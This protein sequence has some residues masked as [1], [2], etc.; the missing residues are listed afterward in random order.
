MLYRVIWTILRILFI[1]LGLKSEGLEN[2][3][4][5]GSFIIASNHVS[6]WDP[7]A[8]AVSIKRQISFIAKAEL[9]TNA[10]LGNLL[11]RVN[12]FPVK[13]GTADRKAIKQALEVLEQGKILG[14][15][16]EGQRKIGR[17]E[18]KAHAGIAM[19][20]LKSHVPVIPVACIGT[21]HKIPWGWTRPLIVKV[22][23]PI[24]LE[25]YREQKIN[26][27]IMEEVSVKIMQ[28]INTLLLK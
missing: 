2:I 15:F 10:L 18:T 17:M 6:N 19:L 20:A 12:A 1:L 13:R 25:E 11:T 21:N 14:I 3:P 5:Q 27:S 23:K 16:P 24:C 8:V 22:G 7:I 28:E 26:S 9:F 4:R